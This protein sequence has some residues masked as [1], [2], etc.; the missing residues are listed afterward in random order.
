MFGA[1]RVT[2]YELRHFAAHFM[3]VT[4]GLPERV[5]GAQLGH[6]DGGRLVRELYGHG[7]VGAL[8]EVERA[9]ANVVPIRK[10]AEK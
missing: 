1:R 7:D 2:S 6:N 4:L 5:V 8:A 9:F 3:L 10:A